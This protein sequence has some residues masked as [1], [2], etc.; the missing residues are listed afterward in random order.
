M[1]ICW[2]EALVDNWAWL[3]SWP[4]GWD[5]AGSW[6]VAWSNPA[7]G[8]NAGTGFSSK[9]A[10]STVNSLCSLPQFSGSQHVYCPCSPTCPGTFWE[11][12][13]PLS[14]VIQ[15]RRSLWYRQLRFHLCVKNAS[16]EWANPILKIKLQSEELK[17]LRGRLLKEPQTYSSWAA[18]SC[19]ASLGLE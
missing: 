14:F 1:P 19:I 3:P 11:G 15:S 17:K 5:P 13:V 4:C 2:N 9:S 10:Y 6:A 8:R 18:T 12:V 16:T 7:P